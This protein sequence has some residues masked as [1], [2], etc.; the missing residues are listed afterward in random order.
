MRR[1]HRRSIRRKNNVIFHVEKIS[2]ADKNRRVRSIRKIH[3]VPANRSRSQRTA[4]RRRRRKAVIRNLVAVRSV[5]AMPGRNHG[6]SPVIAKAA[7]NGI[8]PAAHRAVAAVFIAA[9]ARAE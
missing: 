6:P 9:S 1:P 5:K 3:R 4:D 2:R 8:F 7:T